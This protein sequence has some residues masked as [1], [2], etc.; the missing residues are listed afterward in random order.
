M[1]LPDVHHVM[2]AVWT[3]IKL[4]FSEWNMLPGLSFRDVIAFETSK[5]GLVNLQK[6]Y[7]SHSYILKKFYRQ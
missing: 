7:N 6:N 1:L 3:R 4:N 5:S 2:T